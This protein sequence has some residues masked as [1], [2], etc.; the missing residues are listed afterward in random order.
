[1]PIDIGRPAFPALANGLFPAL[2]MSIMPLHVKIKK[3]IPQ[4]FTSR[5]LAFRGFWTILTAFIILGT[6]CSQRAV[7][8]P[9]SRS[10][11]GNLHKL[12]YTIQVGAFSDVDNAARLTQSL[13]EKNIPAYYFVHRSG[14]YKVRFGNF[15]TKA[16]ARSAAD[17]MKRNGTI[18]DFYIVS[19]ESYPAT[20]QQQ[21]GQQFLR[22]S[23]VKTARSF[24]GIPYKW[25]GTN[26]E[27]GFDCSGLTMA[28]Y[29]LN[30]L[31]L[32]R[33]SKQQFKTGLPVRTKELRKGD[34]VFFDTAGKNRVSHVGIYAGDN[35][36]IH[37]PRQGKNIR[38]TSLNNSYFKKRYLGA[39][40]YF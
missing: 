24:L 36:F 15:P 28:V 34:L 9:Y 25:G 19:P 38:I 12:G 32:P 8:M 23:I 7:F 21:Y 40:T 31:D 6:G 2:L 27:D 3:S 30:G 26:A 22:D 11:D 33:T 37:A 35:S 39:K 14:L 1:M 4:S 5:H 18:D 29:Q 17:A 13:E 20:R 16:A 10:H